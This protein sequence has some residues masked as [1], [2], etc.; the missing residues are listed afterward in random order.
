MSPPC[1]LPPLQGAH[2]CSVISQEMWPGPQPG[3]FSD[4][5]QLLSLLWLWALYPQDY[6][7][8]NVEVQ[9]TLSPGVQWVGNLAWP[10]GLSQHLDVLHTGGLQIMFLEILICHHGS[11]WANQSRLQ[12]W[13][14]F[15]QSCRAG[16]SHPSVGVPWKGTGSYPAPRKDHREVSVSWRPERE[17][18]VRLGGD[19]QWPK[20]SWTWERVPVGARNA[21]GRIYLFG[22]VMI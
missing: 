6:L 18:T 14:L 8:G 10:L 5:G 1:W 12:K 13:T 3:D 15:S 19:L 17:L 4:S 11:P 21:I 20:V 16:Q 22:L 9:H 2:C 7:E